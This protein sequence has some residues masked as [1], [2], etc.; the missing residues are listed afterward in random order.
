MCFTITAAWMVFGLMVFA[1]ANDVF[2]CRRKKR[3]RPRR[4]S[5]G[6][7]SLNI[8]VKTPLSRKLPSVDVIRDRR[9]FSRDNITPRGVPIRVKPDKPVAV[10]PNPE[11]YAAPTIQSFT[12][13]DIDDNM[14]VV[15]SEEEEE[16]TEDVGEEVQEVSNFGAQ[17]EEGDAESGDIAQPFL[18]Y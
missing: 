9:T 17:T 5:K 12:N 3:R 13:Y 1:I 8:N 18:D 14:P 10:L 4:T 2:T 11:S 7:P 6:A 16:G 15:D